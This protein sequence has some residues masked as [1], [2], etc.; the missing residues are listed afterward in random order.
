M[1]A[2]MW[3]ALL[4]PLMLGCSSDTPTSTPAPQIDAPHAGFFVSPAGTNRGDGSAANPWDLATAISQPGIVHPGD[5]IWVHAGTYQGTFKSALTGTTAAPVVLRA[6]PGE[7]AIIDGRF[8]VDGSYAYYWGLEFTYSDPQRATSTPGSTPADYERQHVTLMVLGG[9]NKLINLM[10]HDMGNGFFSGSSA[11]GV[12][13]YGS[14]VYNNGWIGPDRGH[15]H[16]L[17]LQNNT[18]TKRIVDNVIFNNFSTGLKMGG[19]DVAQLKNFFVDGNAVWGSGGPA[20]AQYGWQINVHAQGGAGSLGNIEFSNNSVFTIGVHAMQFGQFTPAVAQFPLN[21]HDNVV[22][23][24]SEFNEWKALTVQNNRFTGGATPITGQDRL[25]LVRLPDSVAVS[26][27][28]WSGNAYAAMPSAFPTFYV[29][30]NG[31]SLNFADIAAW[32]QGTGWD[33]DGSA[34]VGTF[35]GTRVI[36]RPNA[37]ESGRANVIVW[38]WS[39]A[40][41]VSVNLSNVLKSG[42]HYVVHHVYDMFGP[43]VTSGT[44]SGAAITLP[45]GDYTPPAPLGMTAPPPSTGGVFNV[46][47]VQKG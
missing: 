27:Y 15:G 44:Y 32:R 16:G 47:V 29:Y 30:A 1:K 7:R 8:E 40:S 43:P 26:A 20:L 21:V 33:K 14:L 3:I 18:D 9:Y 37:Y 10:L 17:Y 23:G 12:E 5:T 22:Q 35:P 38:N 4:V 36:V 46:F 25:I 34:T 31:A 45:A 13:L 19:T 24:E 11:P 6:Y 42:D 2:A 28:S 41:S 39:G